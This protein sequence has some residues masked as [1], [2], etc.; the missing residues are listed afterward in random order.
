[1]KRYNGKSMVVS[2]QSA[3]TPRV[4]NPASLT[5]RLNRQTNGHF[6]LYW[7]HL[8]DVR[9]L[10]ILRLRTHLPIAQMA[11]HQWL[12]LVNSSPFSIILWVD[13]SFVGR[14]TMSEQ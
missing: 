13:I 5:V 10:Q 11:H 8:M 14:S 4:Y 2:S 3:I 6:H 12:H 9:N 7:T 1:M